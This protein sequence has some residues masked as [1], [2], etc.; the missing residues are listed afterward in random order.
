MAWDES[1]HPRNKDG[2]FTDGN[3]SS[4][5]KKGYDS[6]TDTPV[7]RA[8][9]KAENISRYRK[10]ISS[11]TNDDWRIIRETSERIHRGFKGVAF[12]KGDVHFAM[13]NKKIVILTGSYPH[14]VEQVFSFETH[15]EQIEYFKYLKEYLDG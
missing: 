8:A 1:K 13:V 3:G 14:V 10:K 2:E 11:L 9:K 5:Q 12:Q 15:N 7:S 4:G 6:R